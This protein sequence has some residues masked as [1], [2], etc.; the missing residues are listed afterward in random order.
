MIKNFLRRLWARVYHKR[1][2]PNLHQ[3]CTDITPLQDAAYAVLRSA[4]NKV[5]RNINL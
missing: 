4:E 3:N 1:L 5:R 2:A